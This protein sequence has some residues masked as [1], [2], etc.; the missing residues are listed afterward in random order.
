MADII[1]SETVGGFYVESL[2]VFTFEDGMRV[3]VVPDTDSESPL[4]WGH[5]VEAYVYRSRYRMSLPDCKGSGDTIVSAF[6]EYAGSARRGEDEDDLLKLAMRYART[7]YG[8]NRAAKLVGIQGYSHGDWAEIL[9]IGPTD[10]AVNFVSAN[11]EMYFR[12]DVY[13]AWTDDDSLGGI[14][15]DTAEEAAKYFHDEMSGE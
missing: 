4:E 14:Y 10:S 13:C 8:D 2:E 15:A 7:F 11:Y 1:S 12:G 5:D 6:T 9:F 3:S